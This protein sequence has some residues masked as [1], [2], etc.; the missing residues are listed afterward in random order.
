MNF[1]CYYFCEQ[2]TKKHMTSVAKD[3]SLIRHQPFNRIIIIQIIGCKYFLSYSLNY[4]K[5]I[6]FLII[7]YCIFV[8]E[9]SLNYLKIIIFLIISYCIIIH[10]MICIIMILLNG[11]CRMRMRPARLVSYAFLYTTIIQLKFLENYSFDFWYQILNWR[12]CTTAGRLQWKTGGF[13][14]SIGLNSTIK[15][16][17]NNFFLSKMGLFFKTNCCRFN[18]SFLCR[19]DVKYFSD[20]APFVLKW[21]CSCTQCQLFV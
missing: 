17:I 20:T 7:S 12:F 6:I 21:S 5:I 16:S 10:P 11:W 14:P 8:Y 1:L 4:L 9:Y 15:I 3:H 18:L 2:C 13:I 19:L